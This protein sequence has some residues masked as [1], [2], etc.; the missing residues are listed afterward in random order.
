MSTIP[1]LRTVFWNYDRTLP[2]CDG[3]IDLHG[4]PL[5]IEIMRPDQTFARA[6]QADG[7]D[8]CEA[9][10]S[11]TVTMTSKDACPYVL[12][13]AFLSRAF[14][15]GALFIRTD[16]GISSARDL[17]GKTIGLQE[18]D[19][20][21]SVVVRGLL[22]D[23]YG[24]AASDISWRVGDAERLKPLAFPLGHPPKGVS[25]FQR[26]E[27]SSLEEGLLSGELDAIISLRTPK[28]ADGVQGLVR[29]LFDAQ[30]ERDWFTRRR[31]FPIMHAVAVRRTLA[32][33]HPGLTRRLYDLFKT[34]KDL[35]VSDLEVI[36][37]PKVTLPWPHA[38]AAEVRSIMGHDFWPYGIA[39]NAEVLN[40]QLRWSSE[41]GLQAR[42]IRIE[43]VFA[44]DCLDT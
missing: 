38:I 15:H 41:D 29:A 12:I 32:E 2:L 14:R 28:A 40:T 3:R 30:A 31:I 44:A 19:M 35:A 27:G 36:Q 26:P 17:A 20:T 43:D 9:S 13:P 1:P 7:F 4:L 6:Y 37:A 42:P 24:I 34:A 23:E 8:V 33:Q 11:N 5:R 16:R 22:R 25:I 39:A 21:A 10:F 18:Y